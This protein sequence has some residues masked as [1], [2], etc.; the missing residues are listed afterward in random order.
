MHSVVLIVPAA[1]HAKANAL[2]EAMGYG[3]NNYS[4]QLSADGTAPASHWGLHVWAQQDFVDQL[5]S[6]ELPEGVDYPQADFNAVMAGLIYSIRGTYENHFAEV[7]AAN[8]L[9]IVESE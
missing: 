1:L 2:A 4:I 6:G 5:V 7:V 3:P 8:G 9:Q